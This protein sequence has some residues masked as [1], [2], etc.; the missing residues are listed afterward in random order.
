LKSDPA[1][2][3]E[4]KLCIQRR[5]FTLEFYQYGDLRSLRDERFLY[6]SVGQLVDLQDAPIDPGMAVIVRCPNNKFPVLVG[7]LNNIYGYYDDV[8]I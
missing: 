2:T 4:E 7:V 1:L 5:Y 6:E 8:T 3:L